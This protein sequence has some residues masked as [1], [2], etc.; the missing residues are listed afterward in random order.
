MTESTRVK[1]A[2]AGLYR[3]RHMATDRQYQVTDPDGQLFVFCSV[4][5]LLEYAIYGLPADL[6]PT[7]HEAG[8]SEAAS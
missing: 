2:A 7:L 8:E 3:D 1:C 5:C 6:E 4:C